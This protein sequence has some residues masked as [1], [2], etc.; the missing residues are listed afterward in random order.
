[1]IATTTVSYWRG[2]A[3]T[4]AL[5]DQVDL[6]LV[7]ETALASEVPASLIERSKIVVLPET[8]ERRTVRWTAG[9]VSAVH[10]V[11]KADRLK[12]DRTGAVYFVDEVTTVK[13]MGRVTELALDLRLIVPAGS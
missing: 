3:T 1:M 10:G 9:R 13:S 6:P 8:F 4:N 5:G 12:D 2:G 7:A 11:K